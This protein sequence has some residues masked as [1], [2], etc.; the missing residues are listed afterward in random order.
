MSAFN[1]LEGIF[2]Y[3]ATP[4]A[5]PGIKVLVYETPTQ[6]RTWAQYGVEAWYICHASLHYR[7]FKCYVPA[8]R[9]EH[10]ATS[11]YFFPHDFAVPANNQHD[12]AARSIC[13]LTAALKH[14]YT[15]SPVQSIGDE[16]LL[17]IQ[18][19]EHLLFKT[20]TYYPHSAHSSFYSCSCSCSCPCSSSCYCT[21]SSPN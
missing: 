18:K 16:Q 6:R 5:P 20:K 7:Y 14:I 10:T 8:T 4:M 9:G 21:C 11:I 12:D 13:D 19:L 15:Y 2:D 1:H 17:A 3:N